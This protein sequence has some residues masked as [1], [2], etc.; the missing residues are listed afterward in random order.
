[1]TT[2]KRVWRM[3]RAN[4][5]VKL[6]VVVWIWMGCVTPCPA[7]GAEPS[8]VDH[9]RAAQEDG[10]DPAERESHARA[11]AEAARPG[12][13][14]LAFDLVL[15]V[16]GRRDQLER[17]LEEAGRPIG[18]RWNPDDEMELGFFTDVAP[19]EAAR[20]REHKR[21]ESALRAEEVVLD[22]LC[23]TLARAVARAAPGP[24]EDVV[25][26]KSRVREPAELAGVLGA[27]GFFPT[28]AARR[29]VLDHLN[30]PAPLVGLAAVRACGEQSRAFAPESAADPPWL[31]TFDRLQ[32]GLVLAI[33]KRDAEHQRYRALARKSAAIQGKMIA[34]QV[35]YTQGLGNLLQT[36]MAGLSDPKS[37]RAKIKK[38]GAGIQSPNKKLGPA[39]QRALNKHEEA[40]RKVRAQDRRVRAFMT[41]ASRVFACLNEQ[42]RASVEARLA[43]QLANP[44]PRSDCLQ[45]IEL[46]GSLRSDAVGRALVGA[47]S[48]PSAA[49]RVAACQA[50]G[51][52]SS[53][54]EVPALEVRLGDR[55]WQ[56][57]IAATE[58]LRARGGK[59]SVDALVTVVGLGGGRRAEEIRSALCFLTGK[60]FQQDAV[61]WRKWWKSN[62]DHYRAA[63]AKP[64]APATA[65][66][67]RV[68]PGGFECFGIR[69]HSR[70][71]TFVLDR[72]VAMKLSMGKAVIVVTTSGGEAD[73][74]GFRMHQAREAL[75]HAI[76][77]LAAEVN[78]NVILY[79]DKVTAWKREMVPADDR[80][81]AEVS[82]WL[83]RVKPE[84]E[85]AVF[86]ALVRAMDPS[87]REAGASLR[88]SASDTI[89]LLAGGPAGGGDVALEADIVEEIER[90]NRLH[91]VVIH[92]VAVGETAPRGFLR[93]LA[94][95]CNGQFA[96]LP[97]NSATR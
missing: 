76:G 4:R 18:N 57:G 28:P 3:A 21:L 89:F 97:V 88:A 33:R 42:D 75:A 52:H 82:K 39:F 32:S 1:M 25:S 45:W 90:L 13:W 35:A 7:Q 65:G 84:G 44:R 23:T 24:F 51:W 27:L 14:P 68:E 59:E 30:D 38:A 29:L 66:G 58:S 96:A 9:A 86:D 34:G 15:K 70:R 49:V 50:L 6:G 80:N 5:W 85:A 78:F 79:G 19:A 63:D 74:A 31:E 60:D 2:E 37:A 62:R 83:A 12:D 8:L 54:E 72:S 81:K 91:Q 87:G 94:S 93:S 43:K 17:Q 69:T 61:Q 73:P 71:I 16:V 67:S 77:D 20:Q 48:A 36:A 22:V 10:L 64:G 56:V 40:R 47:A 41:A 55:C 46:C 53:T 26:G 95:R 11:F 92:T